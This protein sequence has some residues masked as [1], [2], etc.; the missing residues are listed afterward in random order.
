MS[1]KNKDARALLDILEQMRAVTSVDLTLEKSSIC[2]KIQALISKDRTDLTGQELIADMDDDE[3]GWAI[4]H[5]DRR[6]GMVPGFVMSP[7]L[8]NY[9]RNYRPQALRIADQ[10][11]KAK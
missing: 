6:I 7:K 3:L 1:F 8:F 9:L 4:A 5:Q 11:S 10:I 2:H